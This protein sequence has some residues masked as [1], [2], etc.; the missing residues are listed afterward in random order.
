MDEGKSCPAGSEIKTQEEC[1]EALK[2]ASDLG[3]DSQNQQQVVVGSYPNMPYQCTYFSSG[4]QRFYFNQDV[5]TN[6]NRLCKSKEFKMICRG[7]NF[8]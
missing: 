7:K 3:M 8:L 6:S 4:D 5:N 1:N 2:L